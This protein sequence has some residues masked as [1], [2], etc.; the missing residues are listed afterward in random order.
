MGRG[1]ELSGSSRD[2]SAHGMLEGSAVMA[3][4]TGSISETIY[5]TVLSVM[6]SSLLLKCCMVSMT[7]LKVGHV[8]CVTLDLQLQLMV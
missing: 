2:L 8:V 7:V 3:G 5:S 4:M 6:E 1:S